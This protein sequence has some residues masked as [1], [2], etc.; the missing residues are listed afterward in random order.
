MRILTISEKFEEYAEKVFLDLQMMGVRV[1]KDFAPEKIGSK[2]RE[3]RMMRIPYLL[4]VGE[5]EAENGA[6]SV[7]SQTEGELGSMPLTDF[8]A[9]VKGEMVARF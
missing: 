9:R 4:I 8:M 6:V 3:G 2:S 1:V 7:R 5:K